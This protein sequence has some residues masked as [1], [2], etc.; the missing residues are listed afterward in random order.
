MKIFFLKK[1]K[2]S[3]TKLLS[4][5]QWSSSL[6]ALEK[7]NAIWSGDYDCSCESSG[8]CANSLA[9]FP[10]NF[11]PLELIVIQINKSRIHQDLSQTET[12]SKAE[13]SCTTD[14]S[15]WGRK[16]FFPG[17]DFKHKSISNTKALHTKHFS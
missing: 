3:K 7:H 15:H 6:A 1:K 4:S 12:T 14:N 2:A 11:S 16:L 9:I 8:V 13:I 10:W 5:V 17:I